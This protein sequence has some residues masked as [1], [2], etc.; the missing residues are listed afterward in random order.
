MELDLKTYL[1]DDI[2]TKVD[3]MSM[4]SS[5]EVRVPLLDHLFV[6][7]AARI[8]TEFKYRGKH[9]KYVLRKAMSG[10]LPDGIL[11]KPKQGFNIPLS[12]WLRT[13]LRERLCD[14]IRG[15]FGGA[16]LFNRP[17]VNTFLDKFLNGEDQH[18]ERL[19][20]LLVFESWRSAHFS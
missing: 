1:P 8:P 2:L 6:E 13:G 16:R 14:T 18:A 9:W 11:H 3:R 15:D 7:F 10:I 4:L 5:L 19:W 20:Q 17:A 12:N